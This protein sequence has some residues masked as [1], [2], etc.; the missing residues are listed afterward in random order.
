MGWRVH[1]VS[2]R[3]VVSQPVFVRATEVWGWARERGWNLRS[4]THSTSSKHALVP[5]TRSKCQEAQQ[6]CAVSLC[7]KWK[8]LIKKEIF[9]IPEQQK[10]IV[11]SFPYYLQNGGEAVSPYK[12]QKSKSFFMLMSFEKLIFNRKALFGWISTGTDA[13]ACSFLECRTLFF[14][15]LNFMAFLLAHPWS[16]PG[17]SGCIPP[18]LVVRLFTHTQCWEAALTSRFAK[19]CC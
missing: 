11:S 19:S 12:E 16:T 5:E 10:E 2:A 4:R 1:C 18:Q 9:P 17:P 13:W 7:Q 3:E 6:I 14:P 8:K 15:L